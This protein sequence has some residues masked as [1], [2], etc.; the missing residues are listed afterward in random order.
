MGE[1]PYF[2]IVGS[3]FMNVITGFRIVLPEY[4]K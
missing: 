1:W 4:P 3:C 2:I